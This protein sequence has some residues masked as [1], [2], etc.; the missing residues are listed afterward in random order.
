MNKLS[1][2]FGRIFNF[3]TIFRGFLISRV[4]TGLN[5]G[6]RVILLNLE[7]FDLESDRVLFMNFD[8]WLLLV[9]T[10]ERLMVDGP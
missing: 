5:L 8:Q 6:S 4:K 3:R 2:E 9:T 7:F 1:I 10:Y